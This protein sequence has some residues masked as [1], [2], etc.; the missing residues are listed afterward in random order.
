MLLTYGGVGLGDA[1]CARFAWG[2][3]LRRTAAGTGIGFDCSVTVSD[4]GFQCVSQAD[5]SAKIAT[6]EAALSA[7]DVNLVFYQTSGVPSAHAVP[8]ASQFSGVRCTSLVWSDAPGAQFQT[9]RKFSATFEWRTRFPSPVTPLLD[10]TET[11]TSRGGTPLTVV[12]EPINAVGLVK[13]VTVPVQKYTAVQEG[14]AVGSVTY[15]VPPAPL[16]GGPSVGL[17]DEVVKRTT[18][19]RFGNSFSEHRVAWSYSFESTSPL[20]ALPNLWT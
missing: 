5:C 1:D 10:F 17:N 2:R 12:Q 3:T 15:P 14:F 18:P 7:E 13:Q 11:V 6:I 4:A 19:R 8:S 9:Y 16:F 20:V